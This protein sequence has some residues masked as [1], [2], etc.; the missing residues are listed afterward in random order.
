MKLQI[1]FIGDLAGKEAVEKL[2]NEI[3]KQIKAKSLSDFED[4]RIVPFFED[5]KFVWLCE[6]DLVQTK[7]LSRLRKV[8]K[9]Y[10]SILETIK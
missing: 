1:K 8:E 10:N 7:E 4:I 5:S 6:L 9:K 2:K 3:I